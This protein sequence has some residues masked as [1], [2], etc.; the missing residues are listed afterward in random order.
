MSVRRLSMIILGLAATTASATSLK[1]YLGDVTTLSAVFQQTTQGEAS[2]KQQPKPQTSVG[3]LVVQSPNKFRLEYDKPYKQIYVADGKRLWSY[4]ADLEQVTVKLQKDLL[5]NLPALVLSNPA[6]LD[7]VYNVN[8]EAKVDN[9]EWFRLTPKGKDS[10][11]ESV[12]LG[13]GEGKLAV[14]EMRDSFGQVT[15]L[16]FTS[17]S[18]NPSV[19]A[20]QFQFTPP[21]GVDV[22]DD[23]QE[24][25]DP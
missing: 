14:F 22:I 18:Y 23:S 17:M 21:A 4:D 7:R 9:L 20:R 19:S 10:S 13:F 11:F 24:A 8:Q 5:A 6:D 16:T 12:R 25:P 3:R 15:R 1:N 2:G